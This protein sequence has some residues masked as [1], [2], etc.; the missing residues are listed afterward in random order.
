MCFWLVLIFRD[1]ASGA[2]SRAYSFSTRLRR[3]AINNFVAVQMKI[4]KNGKIGRKQ[5][6]GRSGC[7]ALFL[8]LKQTG[9]ERGQFLWETADYFPRL[10][11]EILGARSCKHS[12][13]FPDLD[14]YA[15]TRPQ[16]SRREIARKNES[17]R[18]GSQKTNGTNA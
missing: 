6:L 4:D 8:L 16:V 10:V 3:F 12:R 18:N 11:N 9:S 13:Q 5:L 17:G 14:F 1:R 2:L 7:R 15:E